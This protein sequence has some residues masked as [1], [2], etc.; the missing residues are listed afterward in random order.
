MLS[1]FWKMPWPRS[2]SPK[3]K[4]F[5]TTI[6]SPC[7]AIWQNLSGCKKT[8]KIPWKIHGWLASCRIILVSIGEDNIFNPILKGS[9]PMLVLEPQADFLREAHFNRLLWDAEK[10][11]S[12]SNCGYYFKR[13]MRMTVSWWLPACCPQPSRTWG[14]KSRTRSFRP[15]FLLS[16]QI[17]A[18]AAQTGK[19]F[20]FK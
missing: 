10:W 18:R 17:K 4:G 1:F 13:T 20:I 15:L 11:T 16:S 8:M 9:I 12:N 5:F 19:S 14:L 7:H 6:F 2:R 3:C